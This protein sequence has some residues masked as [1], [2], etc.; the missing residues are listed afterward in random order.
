[1]YYTYNK[2]QLETFT[3]QKY[4]PNS[5]INE[6]HKTLETDNSVVT[7][8]TKKW[9]IINNKTRSVTGIHAT[10]MCIFKNKPPEC[11]QHTNNGA[12]ESE[13]KNT[14]NSLIKTVRS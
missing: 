7:K 12:N 1:M 8:Q 5:R 11:V 2:I 3:E 13:F 14:R 6:Y 9:H 10:N 4:T